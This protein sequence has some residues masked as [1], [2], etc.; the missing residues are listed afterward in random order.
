MKGFLQ[1]VYSLHAG[2]K[3][4]D[5]NGDIDRD[6]DGDVAGHVGGDDDWRD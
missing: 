5:V 6:I 2:T 1:I 3:S 4:L